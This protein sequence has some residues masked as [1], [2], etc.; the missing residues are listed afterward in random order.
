MTRS[1]EVYCFAQVA[2]N[3][4][5]GFPL[6]RLRSINGGDQELIIAVDEPS[7]NV[8]A[9]TLTTGTDELTA[10]LQLCRALSEA[11]RNTQS[12]VV[13]LANAAAATATVTVVP[14]I[15]GCSTIA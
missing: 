14:E 9:I 5:A 8:D 15:T 4:S 12:N 6:S 10:A 11:T 13:V 2:D 1:D 7:G 3:D